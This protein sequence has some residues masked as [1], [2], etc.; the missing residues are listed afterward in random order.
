M[1]KKHGIL[2]LFLLLVV[3]LVLK[4]RIILNMY[5][6]ILGRVLLIG[7]VLFFTTCNVALGLLAALCLIIVSN[8]FFMGGVNMEGLT[9]LDNE[10]DTNQMDQAGLTIGDDTVSATDTNAKLKVITKAKAS[11]MT[12]TG[13][14]SKLSELQA[15]AQEQGESEGVDRQ[16]VQ[17]T[18]QSKSSKSIPV[19]KT[20]FESTEVEASEPTTSVTESFSN[21]KTM[22]Y[23]SF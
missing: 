2:G 12:I 15:Q 21:K 10:S 18:I 17:E 19:D 16:T 9:N 23:A 3:I 4:P 11:G 8:M 20:N 22:G 1:Y 7:L 14:G 5:N 13:D 6:N